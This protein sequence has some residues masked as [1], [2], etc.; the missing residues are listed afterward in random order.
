MNCK[1]IDGYQQIRDLRIPEAGNRTLEQQEG[2]R[3]GSRGEATGAAGRSL[4]GRA[5]GPWRARYR[6]LREVRRY[7]SLHEVRRCRNLHDR[8]RCYNRHGHLRYRSRRGRRN[9]RDHLVRLQW[10]PA[11]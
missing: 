9:H 4:R 8:R 5:Y 1:R 3:C 6:N 11:Y 7:R 10:G 2:Q